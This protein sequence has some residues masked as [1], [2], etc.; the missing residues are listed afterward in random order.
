LLLIYAHLMAFYVIWE[1][2]C[3]GTLVRFNSFASRVANEI[4]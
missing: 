3:C 1:T 2:Y 4:L